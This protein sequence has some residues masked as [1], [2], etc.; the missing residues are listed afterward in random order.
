MKAFFRSPTKVSQ[1]LYSGATSFPD[2]VTVVATSV[3]VLFDNIH[4]TVAMS[5]SRTFR[6]KGLSPSRLES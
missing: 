2:K 5:P 3:R 1:L 6:K 4:V